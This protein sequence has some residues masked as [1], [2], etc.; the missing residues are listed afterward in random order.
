MGLDP[1]VTRLRCFAFCPGLQRNE[2]ERAVCRI[3]A[4]EHA[5][6]HH[7]ADLVDARCLQD[8]LFDLSGSL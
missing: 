4:A 2:E 3:H 6:A 5:I 8:D 7:G 1:F